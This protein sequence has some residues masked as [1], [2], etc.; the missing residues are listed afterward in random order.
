MVW[1]WRL[2]LGKEFELRDS[3]NLGPQTVVDAF[4]EELVVPV[5]MDKRCAWAGHMEK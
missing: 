5:I 1:I 3:E 2:W 4:H